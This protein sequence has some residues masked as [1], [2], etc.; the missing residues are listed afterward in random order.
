MDYQPKTGS[1]I[2]N[3][4]RMIQEDKSA[5]PLAAEPS[6]EPGSP[7]REL[8]QQPVFQAE[9]PDS[10]RVAS[11]RPEIE[12]QGEAGG[13][14]SPVS[15]Q[16]L[17][18]A[19]N[20]IAPARPVAPGSP[21]V[22]S[23]SAP[24]QPSQS[25]GQSSSPVSF[26]SIA[27]KITTPVAA[28]YKASAPAK[29]QGQVQGASTK[30]APAPALNLNKAVQ[31]GGLSFPTKTPQR[32]SIGQQIVQGLQGIGTKLNPFNLGSLTKKLF[33]GSSGRG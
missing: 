3:L 6:A 15:P 32:Q 9:S 5:G 13:V 1:T 23:P 4:L 28:G 24:S 31:S 7:I 21:D 16:P 11:I 19:G 27:T 10:S 14:V 33:A 26:P 18:G 8:I 30:A 25:G 2:G 20:V 12:A 29:P 22:V 17:E